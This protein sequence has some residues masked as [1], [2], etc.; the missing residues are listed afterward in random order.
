MWKT[1]IVLLKAEQTHLNINNIIS[2]NSR[3]SITNLAYFKTGNGYVTGC[4]QN[5]ENFT[6]K[7][8]LLLKALTPFFL[9]VNVVERQIFSGKSFLIK[10]KKLQSLKSFIWEKS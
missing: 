9:A 4:H 1:Q 2:H 8:S 10:V 7:T 3:L 6:G 5:T